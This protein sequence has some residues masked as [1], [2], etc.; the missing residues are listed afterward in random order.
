VVEERDELVAGMPLGRLSQ[1]QAALGFERGA[2]GNRLR[3]AV[4]ALDNRR[5]E[6]TVGQQ[7]DDPRAPR[8][9]I[10]ASSSGFKIERP[11][12]GDARLRNLAKCRR[13]VT[14]VRDNAV[15]DH[16]ICRPITSTA[17]AA[18]VNMRG[19]AHVHRKRRVKRFRIDVEG[20]RP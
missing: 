15:R 11:T 12:G 10:A 16:A 18:F 4:D 7:Q 5:V 6:V 13:T 1:H 2:G 14:A 20:V 9:D 17:L 19:Q 3:R 8:A